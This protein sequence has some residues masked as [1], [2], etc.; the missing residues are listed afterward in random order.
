MTTSDVQIVRNLRNALAQAVQECDAEIVAVRTRYQSRIESIER[1]IATFE[2]TSRL[3]AEDRRP[4][5]AALSVGD[6]R[7]ESVRQY[8]NAHGSAR[9]ADLAKALNINSG[10]V[11]VA[12]RRLQLEG[13]VQ[14]LSKDNGST[15]WERVRVPVAA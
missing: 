13:F 12:L 15:R 4:D 6:D 7:L 9:Q 8:M 3:N 14:P 10:S 1:A 5:V 2:G 11:S